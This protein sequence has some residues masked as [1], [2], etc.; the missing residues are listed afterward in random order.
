MEENI[1]K[2]QQGKKIISNIKENIANI[3]KPQRCPSA[4]KTKRVCFNVIETEQG[5]EE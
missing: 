4:Q 3:G 2:S 1:E 5:I